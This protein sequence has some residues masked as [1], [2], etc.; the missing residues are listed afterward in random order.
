LFDTLTAIGYYL[1]DKAEYS[2]FL[3]WQRSYDNLSFT[4]SLFNFPESEVAEEIREISAAGYGGQLM[5]IFY[6]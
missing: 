1:W 6:H 5:I 4:V 3:S 2:L